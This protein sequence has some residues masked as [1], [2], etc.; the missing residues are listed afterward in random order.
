MKLS[1][2]TCLVIKTVKTRCMNYNTAAYFFCKNVFKAASLISLMKVI[3]TY[4]SPL[5][6]YYI[7]LTIVGWCVVIDGI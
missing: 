7:Y 5:G 1:T 6:H 4:M 2:E 3:H